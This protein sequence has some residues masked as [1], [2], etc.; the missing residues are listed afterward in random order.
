MLHPSP[1]VDIFP[2]TISNPALNEPMSSPALIER[3]WHHSADPIPLLHHLFPMHGHHSTPEQPRKLRLYYAACARRVY[4]RLNSIQR[5]FLEAAER[6]ADGSIPKTVL[7]EIMELGEERVDGSE[8]TPREIRKLADLMECDPSAWGEGVPGI[9]TTDRQ[10]LGWLAV[11]SLHYRF[12]GEQ[13]QLTGRARHE[14]EDHPL[15]LGGEMR[16]LGGQWTRKRRRGRF[17]VPLQETRQGNPTEAT[18]GVSQERSS[19]DQGW[20]NVKG[21]HE[22]DS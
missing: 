9:D 2:S 8:V 1:P 21:I 5:G 15:R 11:Q 7:S 13:V 3:D 12:G 6:L 18:G 10:R 4:G 14:Q 22:I 16:R 17:R 19:F 20:R